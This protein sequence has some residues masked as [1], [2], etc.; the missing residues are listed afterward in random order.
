MEQVLKKLSAMNEK[1]DCIT[2]LLMNKGDASK[3]EL[4]IKGIN[5]R[6]L[7]ADC[8]YAYG[9]QLMDVLFTKEEMAGSLLL[10]SKLST[11]PALDKE[12]VNKLFK[13]IEDK[14]KDN[15]SYKK[16]LES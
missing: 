14:F 16:A 8:P 4:T 15:K 11:K 6:R 5:V 7:H 2:E 9:L 12:R 13:L 1:L 3:Q 10:E